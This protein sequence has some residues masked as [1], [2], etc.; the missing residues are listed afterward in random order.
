MLEWLGIIFIVLIVL[1]LIGK[2]NGP[3]AEPPGAVRPTTLD[4]IRFKYKGREDYMPAERI[5]DA[6]GVDEDYFEGWCRKRNARRTFRLD[7]VTGEVVSLTTGEVFPSAE[8][9]RDE[10]ID[11]PRNRG[12]EPVS[13]DHWKRDR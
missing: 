6:E 2:L 10:Y 8:A 12:V 4:A 7:R 1:A 11:D 9:W 5:V 3:K 13:Q